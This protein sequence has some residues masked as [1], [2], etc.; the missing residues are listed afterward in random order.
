[1]NVESPPKRAA[2]TERA[3]D[4]AAALAQFKTL[5]EALEYL[6]R[7][8]THLTKSER[9]SLF[10]PDPYA[11]QLY[12]RVALG[13]LKHEI[14]IDD[15]S[16]VAGSVF[17][18]GEASIVNDPYKDKRFNRTVD[19]QFGFKTE[20]MAC[21]PITA[22]GD[23]VVGVLQVLNR[24]TGRFT[25]RDATILADVA[26]QCAATLHAF[27]LIEQ[28]ER[29]RKREMEFMNL[30]SKLTTELDLTTLLDRVVAA[31]TE[32]LD[33]ERA[34]IFLNDERHDELFSLV[35]AGMGAQEIRFP[36]HMGLAGT[37]FQ[38]G[39]S[40]NIPHAY[41]DL[42]FNPAFD[43]QTGF[44]TR[45]LLCVPIVNKA[46]KRIGVTQ[47][48]NKAG[49]PFSEEDESRIKAFTA[50]IA[51]G[52]ENAKLFNDIRAM[53]N[54]TDS[55]L[56]SMSNGVLTVAEGGVVRTANA[57]AARIFRV[58]HASLVGR[59]IGGLLG[60]SN[61]WLGKEIARVRES[62][63]EALIADADVHT[64]S[65]RVS[66]DITLQPL[67]DHTGEN[68]GVLVLINDISDAKR[69]RT[70]LSRYMDPRLAVDLMSRGEADDLMGGQATEASILFTDIRSFTSISEELG[71]QRTV[72]MLNEYF[73]LMVHCITDHGGML[74][75]FIGD[76]M[77]AGFGVPLPDPDAADASVRAAIQML[78][79]LR[80]WNA[81]REF[82]TKPPIAMGCGINTDVV[83]TGNIGSSK[84]MDFTMIG[85]GV[86]LAARLES[87]CKTY[88][89]QLLISEFTQKKLR[90]IYALREL[91][92]IVVKGKSKPIG[93][94]EVLD[95]HDEDTFPNRMD[96]VGHFLEGLSRYRA[97]RFEEAAVQ[98][99]QALKANSNDKPSAMYVERCAHFQASPPPE[100]WCG[101]WVMTSK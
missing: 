50:Q 14:R 48:L 21:V 20:S 66:A 74:D 27:N 2:A 35:A 52:L 43:K 101:E 38:S 59:E 68:M 4:V 31:A 77:M 33:A 7:L 18:S 23:Q 82:D 93:V 32:M 73:E 78:F 60:E 99:E 11:G 55:M 19:E 75:K 95:F 9:A 28:N 72:E 86:N 5:D 85:D 44:F 89:A 70:T 65:G 16:G 36:N 57:A 24:R 30:V 62:G 80:A 3:A 76:A 81:S 6:V 67:R 34:T 10:L 71:P 49:G 87:A 45:S 92:R 40:V 61:A 98:F 79:K 39:E 83:V 15:R 69:A 56:Q 90:G 37:V 58:D 1:M 12:A 53:Q 64:G 17:Q 8:V 54:Y 100:D 51:I 42:R 96:T 41:A 97:R 22:F 13:D 94:Y 25:K 63:E 84:R 88:G 47:A 26:S 29:S 46:G 91:D